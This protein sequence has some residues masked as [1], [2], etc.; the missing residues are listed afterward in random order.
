M[1]H[2]SSR[3]LHAASAAARRAQGLAVG[4][5]VPVDRAGVVDADVEAGDVVG[6]LQARDLLGQHVA[7]ERAVARELGERQPERLGQPLRPGLHRDAEG[8]L[9]VAVG[10]RVAEGDEP[11]RRHARAARARPSTRS[12]SHP[13]ASSCSGF[14]STLRST[15]APSASGSSSGWRATERV[16]PEVQR[17]Q[18]DRVL[19]VLHA[20]VQH[21]AAGG[22]ERRQRARPRQVGDDVELGL[23][24]QREDV[25]GR[26]ASRPVERRAAPCREHRA[27]AL[28][29]LERQRLQR[30][31]QPGGR[32]AGARALQADL[33][34]VQLGLGEV[35]ERRV[36]AIDALDRRVG[37]E[38]RAA[39]VGLKA[40]L[41]GVDDDRV[42][43]R[44]RRVRARARRA[45]RRP[46][47]AA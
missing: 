41:V 47:P 31:P 28:V 46:G 24:V 11:A 1:V 10:D 32:R 23:D 3:S 39:A 20:G 17:A 9:A 14:M 25:G 33:A 35:R 37:E 44:D 4:G 16:A 2:S 21:G 15:R 45:G 12:C 13:T 29:A 7:R 22:V 36:V 27:Q 5:G 43:L 6:A 38:D 19:G 34:Q 8:R 42:A 40:V 30:Q 26:Q 18:E